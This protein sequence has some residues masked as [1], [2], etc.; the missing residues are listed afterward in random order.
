MNITISTKIGTITDSLKPLITPIDQ[1]ISSLPEVR[2][3]TIQADGNTINIAVR[4]VKKD[5]RTKNSFEIEKQ[6]KD[7][8]NYLVQEGYTVETKV[9]EG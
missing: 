7:D 4:T 5:K 1:I 8:L 3:Y 6:I 2:N 9:Q